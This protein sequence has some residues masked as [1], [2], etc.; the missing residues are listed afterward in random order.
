MDDDHIGI[1]IKMLIHFNYEISRSHPA[2]NIDAEC[3]NF[4]E[5]VSNC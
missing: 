1:N 4:S 3:T 5:L 2:Y